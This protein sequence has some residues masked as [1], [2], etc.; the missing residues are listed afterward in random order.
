MWVLIRTCILFTFLLLLPDWYIYKVYVAPLKNHTAKRWLWWPTLALLAALYGFVITREVYQ[1]YFGI[2]LIVALAVCIPKVI[3]VLFSLLL[4]GLKKLTHWN[5]RHGIIS[6]FPS[7]AA[8]IYIIFGATEGKQHFQIKEVTFHSAELPS[9]FDGYRI[10]QLS[11]IHSGSWKGNP[12]PLQRAID[13]CNEQHADLAVFT[14]D[15]VNSRSNE[16]DEFVPVLSQLKAK[17][18]V[19][20]IL[21]N[22]DYGLYS[23]W[24]HDSLRLAD[25]DSLISRQNHMGWKMLNNDHRILHRGNDSIAL[26]GVENSGN[27]PFPDLGDLNKASRGTDG[28]FKV[29]LS[30]DPTHW[31]RNVLPETDIQLMLAGHTHDMQISFLGFSASKFVYPEHNGMYYE[32]KRGLYVNI[33]LG[34][35]LFPMRLGAWPEITVITLKKD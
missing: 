8:G 26:I 10:L 14:G 21:G 33:G 5:I 2:F 25:V 22:H 16:L 12:A 4:R 31:R 17:D 23:I 30:H 19:Y 32:G 9:D 13:L 3:F 18:G 7:V 11:D 6:I 27:P 15:M 35:V 34:H 1:E 28:M 29:L 20:S 24:E